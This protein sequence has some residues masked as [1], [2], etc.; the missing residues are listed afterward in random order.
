MDEAIDGGLAQTPAGST[1]GN[2]DEI[3]PPS[4]LLEFLDLAGA[5]FYSAGFPGASG[6]P[7]M[8]RINS[9]QFPNEGL[10]PDGGLE[11]GENLINFFH[12]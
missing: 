6:K 2:N 9:F 11:A 12:I 8:L 7:L 3:H 5:E 4:L 1:I 10:F